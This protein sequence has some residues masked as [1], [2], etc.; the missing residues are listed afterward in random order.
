MQCLWRGET[1]SLASQRRANGSVSNR[2]AT[3]GQRAKCQQKSFLFGPRSA[4][5]AGSS[6]DFHVS[7]VEDT[8]LPVQLWEEGHQ[9]CAIASRTRFASHCQ[10]SMAHEGARNDGR[11]SLALEA[12]QREG[13]M[14][15]SAE[16]LGGNFGPSIIRA[17]KVIDEGHAHLPLV[18]CHVA[19]SYHVKSSALASTRRSTRAAIL[20]S[21]SGRK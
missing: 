8:S 5:L 10:K 4:D 6:L 1:S 15:L 13:A 9:W 17:K 20:G 11:K 14:E 18:L 19:V 21:C 3:S 2:A 12:I 16:G 7:K